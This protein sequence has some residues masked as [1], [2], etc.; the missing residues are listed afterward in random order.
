MKR[1]LAVFLTLA[2]ALN[3]APVAA[4]AA[5]DSDAASIVAVEETDETSSPQLDEE[6]ARAIVSDPFLQAAY[7][8]TEQE[9]TGQSEVDTSKVS[10]TATDSFG[11]LLANGVNEQNG[12]SSDNTSRITKVQLNGHT[13]NVEFVTDE[14]ADLVVAVYADS[15]AEE[16]VAS[17][18][19]K[20]SGDG[21]NGSSKVEITGDIPE[22]Y[23]VK[24]YLLRQSDHSPLSEAYTD[25]SN[26][27]AIVEIK[28]AKISDFPEDRVVNLDENDNT[29]FVVV[30]EAV[31]LL[32]Y[33][34][35]RRV[36]ISLSVRT[37]PG[38]S[39]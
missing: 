34:E 32:T 36:Q 13:A 38:W 20:V 8:Q 30:N 33:E 18:T 6:T 27:Q 11:Q 4:F 17:G 19:E 14:A 28:D 2:M 39:M 7:A 10:M 12:T 5:A 24:A 25:T 31:T 35:T 16:M 29:N 26:T 37:M 1:I 21:G 3:I 23:T 9:Q 22:Y 15:A